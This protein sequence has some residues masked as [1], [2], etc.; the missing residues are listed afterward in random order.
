M[1]SQKPEIPLYLFGLVVAVIASASLTF[2][3]REF[4][5]RAGLVDP[6]SERK[7]HVHPVPRIGGVAIVLAGALAM[8]ATLAVFG[9]HGLTTNARGLVTV[10]GGAL[11]V[12]VVGLIDDIRPMRAR[13]KFLAQIVIACGVFL[14]GSRVTTLS[15]PFVGT[16]ELG[17][18]V[19]MLFTVIWFVGI[20]NA[21]N[22][23][24][25]LDGL[26]AGAALFALTTMFVV[27]SFNGLIGA[28]TVTIILAGA[29][30]GFLCFNFHP[31]SIFLG[32]SGSLF[33]GFMLAGIGLLGSQKSP[34]VIAVAIPIVSL[35]LPVLDTT[36][37]VLRRFLRGQPIFTADR[38]HIHHRLL[39]LGHSPRNVAL[40]LY[41]ACALLGLGGMLLVNDSAY[42]AVVLIVIGLGVGLA[43]QRLRYYEFEELARLLK[44]G[45]HQRKNIGRNVRIR[46]AS[47]RVSDL[48]DL[49]HVFDTLEATF[50]EDEFECA[51][52]RLR[53]SFVGV[54][55]SNDAYRRLDDDVPVW[56]WRR[57]DVT[58]AACWE[59]RLPFL[60]PSGERIGSL[61]LWQDGRADNVSL[62]DMHA[63]AH[64]LR[65]VVEQK[66]LA[67]WEPWDQAPGAVA[68]VGGDR[69]A[70]GDRPVQMP[71]GIE[72]TPLA[73]EKDRMTGA[74]T[75]AGA[76]RSTRT[77]SGSFRL[78]SAPLS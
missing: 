5:R 26:A 49:D 74:K 62:V 25:G 63:I 42:V 71:R 51:E 17:L 40:L 60:A 1:W 47:L 69:G 56:A 14:A 2:V 7:V 16:V 31:A 68:A 4:A 50:A 29:T 65:A 28:A 73:I 19:G 20:T 11:A 18:V 76:N 9:S 15:L 43:V 77:S 52:V 45:V 30:V 32:D 46:E 35:G 36:L 23:I 44:R 75:E 67:L 12:H 13:W 10:I 41:G 24:D 55:P 78:R 33:L 39:S 6:C 37:A 53:R 34:T 21:F 72:R 48:T 57:S 64:D 27:A 58:L 22:L 70:Q 54:G 59:I 61:V 3:V 8:A 66:L 38:A